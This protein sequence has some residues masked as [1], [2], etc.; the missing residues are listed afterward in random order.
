MRNLTDLSKSFMFGRMIVRQAY[1][2]CKKYRILSLIIAVERAKPVWKTMSV[3]PKAPSRTEVETLK[4]KTMPLSRGI[5][6]LA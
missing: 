2:T 4:K 3:P 5:C 6:P 1:A